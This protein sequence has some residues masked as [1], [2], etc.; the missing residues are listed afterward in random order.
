MFR[1]ILWLIVF[2]VLWSLGIIQWLLIATGMVM[3]W[4]GSLIVALAGA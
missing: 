3:L 4:A 1:F 2:A